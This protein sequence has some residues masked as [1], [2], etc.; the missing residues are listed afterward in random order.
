MRKSDN[1]TNYSCD[2]GNIRN[3]VLGDLSDLLQM[4]NECWTK[5][6]RSSPETIRQRIERFSE[7][8]F[9]YELNGRV[10]GV[11]Y[12]QR[13]QSIEDLKAVNFRNVSSLHSAQGNITQ[14][15]ALNVL[16][17]F[18]HLALGDKLLTFILS[19]CFTEKSC[20]MVVAVTLCQNYGKYAH[21]SMEEY[22]R[23]CDEQ[24][25]RLD[26][27]LRFHECHGA[28]IEK[29]MPGYRPEDTENQGYGVL[30][31]YDSK[32]YKTSTP[33]YS[34]ANKNVRDVAIVIKEYIFSVIG[35]DMEMRYSSKF[36][37]MDMGLES[38][39]LFGLRML[40]SRELGVELD[41][42]FFFRYSTPD[43]IIAYFD[44]KDK[45]LP[46]LQDNHSASYSSL[47]TESQSSNNLHDRLPASENSVAVIGM[48]CRF[49]RSV[50]G[51]DEYW[52]L[53][54]NG[55]DAITEIP[56]SRWDV[57][58]YY[59]QNKDTTGKIVSR[60]GGFLDQVDR[61][62]SSFFN[63]APREA[64]NTDPQQ[65]ILLELTWEALE[66]AGLNPESLAGTQTGV[67]VGIFSNDYELLQIKY[68]GEES[69]DFYFATGNSISIAAGRI[70]YVFDFQG[71]AIAVNTACSS[72]LVAVHLACQNLR[73]L[74]CDLAVASGI[75]LL[76]SPELSIAFS[77][78]GMLSP[79][80]RC[81]TF[82]ADANGYVRSEG[83]GVVVL[84][85]LSD[86][87][88]DN[89]N[90]L[91]VIRGTAINH[92]GSSNGL[93]APN[94]LS[95]EAVIR[96][97]ISNA[98]VKPDDVSYVEA[99]GTGTPL[100]DPVELKALESVYGPGRDKDNPLT[101]GSVKTNIG[102]TEAAAGI[103]GL[104]KVILSMQNKYIPSNLHFK[105]LN[106]LIS[107]DK[108]NGRI[109]A[110]GIEW[111]KNDLT[112]KYIAGVSSFGF[113]GTNAHIILEEAPAKNQLKENDS[114]T[115]PHIMTLSAKSQQALKELTERYVSYI[116][117]HGDISLAD[118]CYTSNI[119]RA[120]FEYRLAV[121]AESTSDM[122]ANL[123]SFLS[124]KQCAGF[125]VSCMGSKL[126]Q[127]ISPLLQHSLSGEEVDRTQLLL[128]LGDRYVNGADIDWQ[129]FYR[130]CR[131]NRIELP[132][133]PF[134]RQRYWIDVSR[135]L[136][137]SAGLSSQEGVTGNTVEEENIFNVEWESS[138][139]QNVNEAR[140]EISTRMA[141]EKWIILSDKDGLGVKLAS[142][143]RTRGAICAVVFYGG[144]YE[145]TSPDKFT[146]D[147]A[148]AE[149]FKRFMND[150]GVE[151]GL[152]GIIHICGHEV[153]E[154]E[155]IDAE[156]IEE[157]L[158]L[159]CRSALYTVQAL[160]T[161]NIENVNFWL[162]T[163]GA[164][165]DIKS[166]FGAAQSS[167]W[168]LGKVI[169]REHPK[170]HCRLVDIDPADSE[171]GLRM[172]TEEIQSGEP[173]DT[174][175]FLSFHNGKR[176]TSRFTRALEPTNMTG[177]FEISPEGSYLITGGLGG[178]GLNVAAWLVKSGAKHVVLIGRTAPIK[179]KAE[180]IKELECKGCEITVMRADVSNKD[181][182]TVVFDEIERTM[183]PLNG[184]FHCAGIFDD[185]LL[186]N[187]EWNVFERVFAAKVRGAWNLHLLSLKKKVSIF[188]LFSSIFSILPE[189]GVGNYAAANSFMDALAQYRKT[190]GLPGLSVNWGPWAGDGMAQTVGKKRMAQW[191][192]RGI[193]A[194][195]SECAFQCLE[196]LIQRGVAGAT[197]ASLNIP[198]LVQGFPNNL[199]RS[200]FS[201]L[202]EVEAG[203]VIDG[204][205]VLRRLETASKE[206]RL[207]ILC[208][209]VSSLTA[210]VLGFNLNDS[211]DVEK[212]FFQLGM[213][214]LTSLDMRNRLE[215][216]L[217][218]TFS[219]TL[220][221]KY[222]SIGSL[223]DYLAEEV[224]A[225]LPGTE[226]DNRAG[227][228]D[229]VKDFKNVEHLYALESDC[230]KLDKIPDCQLEES[231]EE[232][233]EKLERLLD[234][235]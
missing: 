55:K 69:I 215:T 188:A 11:I 48:S 16:P 229:R 125:V 185:R 29:L 221:F 144:T 64:I 60:F 83:G 46:D 135:R 21:L 3:P 51:V 23:S 224:F 145:R 65:R 139:L 164:Q 77:R 154:D 123:N 78:S 32:N 121:I 13:I 12:S 200:F 18:K 171:Q 126:G 225:A 174:R 7:E 110:Q 87:I 217:S 34:S 95:Q 159:W 33:E 211:L 192:S 158:A 44:S 191:A 199:Q 178:V 214:S 17:A 175:P 40:I 111:T 210:T 22:F 82:D 194:L 89:D 27:I 172:L 193:N 15:L 183:P 45:R 160:D 80:G 131:K 85:R 220:L 50:N 25:L 9:V 14:L 201:G 66:H 117:A 235:Q 212:G 24:G 100:G 222:P 93:T 99:H 152:T 54:L 181:E 148:K 124:G 207:D 20:K 70:S 119:G 179:D 68:N 91:A 205:D 35:N 37:L 206:N 190:L 150:F 63:I 62:D 209:Y 187:H 92:D 120:H 47:P 76:L 213:D 198:K 129:N 88:A 2:K 189:A 227:I 116:S 59:S 180:R 71:P 186:V 151:S 176:Y 216:G 97:A 138:E 232:E 133:Y 30:V 6:L 38:L 26:P 8:H 52:Q 10:V 167:L 156:A 202:C 39:D 204:G 161:Y 5:P 226:I 127:A 61:F 147:S 106:P 105:T 170:F 165:H 177:R 166:I 169:M 107:L 113:S 219:S 1:F 94:G 36:A 136:N 112:K 155:N 96:K 228:V 203:S 81:K 233:L 196:V 153:V 197:V 84:K 104:I 157:K 109:S 218:R 102:H 74:E 4:E 73:N 42:S 103:A 184:V 114:D 98:N 130:H 118:I 134:Q 231:V 146:I 49:P 43:A 90:I 163:Q 168:G 79:D 162:I 72:S 142:M 56:K 149:D 19:H 128:N 122:V 53:L 108:M 173:S 195:T 141:G 208:E 31:V 58:H 223:T 140:F 86:A 132:T 230:G 182:L 41:P 234:T 137:R 28:K 101:I 57:N 67:F 143:L 75:N 115:L